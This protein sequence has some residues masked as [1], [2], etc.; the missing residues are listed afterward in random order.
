MNPH[1][2]RQKASLHSTLVQLLSLGA[3]LALVTGSTAEVLPGQTDIG[4]NTSVAS[5]VQCTSGSCTVL[6]DLSAAGSAFRIVESNIT[7]DCAGHSLSGDGTGTALQLIEPGGGQLQSINLKHCTISNFSDG[8]VVERASSVTVSDNTIDVAGRGV[9]F[10]GS[11]SFNNDNGSL[12]DN[13][14]VAGD[15]VDLSGL[16]TDNFT[17]RGNTLIA[18][19]SGLGYG[20]KA[21][22]ETVPAPTVDIEL[23][24][25]YDFREGIQVGGTLTGVIRDNH[26]EGN[27]KVG[28]RINAATWTDGQWQQPDR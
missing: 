8:V 18:K 11:G 23:N 17:L 26:L 25:I 28:A 10:T 3:L 14:I 1:A 19:T 9:R 24:A 21:L 22:I 2:G 13:V 5:I 27:A 7:F 12:L 16:S 20:V 15:G 6:S 4:A